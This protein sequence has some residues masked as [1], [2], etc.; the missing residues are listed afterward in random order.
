MLF[1]PFLNI[2]DILEGKANIP[3]LTLFESINL[4]RYLS[5]PDNDLYC[6]LKCNLYSG[7]LS[8]RHPLGLLSVCDP[9]FEQDGGNLLFVYTP[10]R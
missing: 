1:H 8:C 10:I 6:P 3:I 2:S 4:P 5:D 7:P 9:S